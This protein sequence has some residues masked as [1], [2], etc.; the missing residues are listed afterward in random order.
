MIRKYALT[1]VLLVVS[2]ALFLGDRQARI[3]RADSIGK[4]VYYPFIQSI[5]ILDGISMLKKQN[6]SLFQHNAQLQLRLRSLEEQLLTLQEIPD[7]ATDINYVVANLVGFHGEFGNRNIIID[8]GYLS[9]IEV[10]NPVICSNGVVGKIILTAANH[11]VIL[12]VQHP[13][14]KLGVLDRKTRVQGLLESS[15]SGKVFMSMIPSD[16]AIAVGD[17]IITS[18]LS[19]IFPRGFPVGFVS[20]VVKIPGEGYQKAELSTFVNIS[21]MEQV[22]VL[23]YKRDSDF[24]DLIEDESRGQ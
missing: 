21:S 14:F 10:N 3:H 11:S 9:G 19:R 6:L 2:I 16:A 8:Q 18:N 13:E 15:A 5:K 4:T 7:A 12:P 17:T 20:K 23:L 22:I 24:D 1:V